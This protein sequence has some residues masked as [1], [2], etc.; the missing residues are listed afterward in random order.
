MLRDVYLDLLTSPAKLQSEGRGNDSKAGPPQCLVFV[1]QGC[2]MS[3]I[4]VGIRPK[5]LKSPRLSFERC[6]CQVERFL[7]CPNLRA[8]I[9][10]ARGTL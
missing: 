8:A 10:N 3:N 7:T 5:Q 1:P 9:L 4:K 6:F 2:K